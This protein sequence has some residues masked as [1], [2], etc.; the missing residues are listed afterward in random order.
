[1]TVPI[2]EI[3]QVGIGQRLHIRREP[4]RI[5]ISIKVLTVDTF[6]EQTF[7]ETALTVSH[8]DITVLIRLII[9]E[10]NRIGN[11]VNVCN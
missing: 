3:S 4:E 5:E 2:G 10:E 8:N 7:K 6:R 9:G 1:M 11:M